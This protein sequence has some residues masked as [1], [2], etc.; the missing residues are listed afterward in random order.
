M[1]EIS[2]FFVLLLQLI[3]KFPSISLN[4]YLQVSFTSTLFVITYSVYKTIFLEC[5]FRYLLLQI[6]VAF[7]YQ[8]DLHGFICT[9]N[10]SSLLIYPFRLMPSVFQL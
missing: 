4:Y 9:A 8:S 2:S 1:S 10:A 7:V 3:S 5:S 6:S